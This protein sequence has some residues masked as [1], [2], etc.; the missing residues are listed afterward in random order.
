[1][2]SF[3]RLLWKSL[4]LSSLSIVLILLFMFSAV[5]QTKKVTGKVINATTKEPVAGATVKV[6]G[7]KELMATGADG[8]FSLAVPENATLEISAVGFATKSVTADFTRMMNISLAI[9]N[10][11][12]GEVVVIGYG[13]KK[14]AT[15]TGSVATIDSKMFQDRGPTANP[16][17][18]LQGQVPGVVVTRSS[19]A[20]GRENWNFQIRGATS[21]NNADPLV[22]VDGIPLVSLNALNSINPND[23]ESMSFL[24]DASSAIYGARAAGGVVLITTKKAKAGKPVIQYDGSVTRKK[25]GL[26]P[27][28]INVKQ[29]GEGL[30]QAT[31]NDWYGVAPTTNLWYRLGVLQQNAPDSGYLDMNVK[32]NM[33]WTT[34]ALTYVGTPIAPSS[35]PANPGFGDVKDFTFFNTNWVDALWGPATS[36]QHN[37]SLSQRSDKAGFRLSLGYMD[38]GSLLQWGDNSNK[39]YNVRLSNDYTFSDKLKLETIVSLEK[40]DIVQPTLINS[41]LSQFQQPG[42]PIATKNGQPYGW[43][44]QYS[45]NWLAQLG[46]DQ[47]EYNTRVFANARATYSFTKHLRFIGQA[48]YN[49]NAQD[50]KT[51]QKFITNWYNYAGYQKGSPDNPSQANSYYIRQLA[52]E[53]YYNLNGYFEYQNSYR[54]HNFGLTL[55]GNYER[56]ENNVYSARTNYL[57]NNDVPSLNLGVGDATTKSVNENNN[58]YAIG[59][60]FGRLNYAYN[61]KYLFEANARYDGSSKLA[62][63]KRWRFFYGF[64]AGWR[65]SQEDFMKNIN[66][67]NDLKIRASWGAVGNQSNIGLYDYLQLLG[68]GSNTSGPTNNGYPII[69]SGTVVYV[70]PTSLLTS[71]QRTWEKVETQNLAVD[72]TV[73]NNRLS[74]TV[75]YFIKNNTNMLL[76]QQFPAVLGA[77]APYLN[78]GHLRTWGWEASVRWSDKIGKVSYFVGGSI[79]DNRNKLVQYQANSVIAPGYNTAVQG[80]PVGSYFGLQYAGRIQDDK[81][82]QDYIQLQP[83]NNI[84]MPATTGSLP[85]VRIGDNMFKDVDGDGKLTTPGDLVYL[86]RDDPRY[87]YAFNLGVQW[88]GFDFAATFQ[89]VGK[90]TIFREGNWRVP[91]GSIFQGQTT[92]WWG[93]TWTPDNPGAYYP[94]LSA[95]QN[96]TTYNTYNYQISTW[97]VEN[98]A[99]VRLKNLVIGYTIPQQYVQKAHIQKL[100]VYFSGNDLWEITHIRDGFDPEA[101]RS[102]GRANGESAITR[103]PF[104]R[105]MTA[106]VNLTF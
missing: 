93:K 69:G 32:Y 38:D 96:A 64:S 56:D 94:I 7:S 89:G 22:V 3:K 79:T 66:W 12:L 98:G 1:M 58:H 5:A 17:A 105:Y 101:T 10:A 68:V 104:Y 33:D 43:G 63:D 44:T 67:L 36:T 26:Q 11:D 46:G 80:Y 24:K 55:G 86:G 70:D 50:T 49:W 25:V 27:H 90:R 91:F 82:R 62:E 78:I 35:N 2:R 14:K 15:L 45:P 97:S 53:P 20:P 57:A 9:N 60:F 99:Y 59:S 95:G 92:F 19:A 29:F 102:V 16:M 39:R 81:T 41:V 76:P 37:I 47:K 42:F 18:A 84:S 72:A 28:M 65:L 23:I 88:N 4:S 71:T 54:A 100:R 51:E 87:T 40:N 75:E 85:G 83:G 6:K 61:Q 106:G 52:K 73:L 74:T 103:Y 30:V 77:T 34:G 13:E 8:S 31:T 21:T 48:G